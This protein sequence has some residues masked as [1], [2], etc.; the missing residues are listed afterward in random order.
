MDLAESYLYSNIKSDLYGNIKSALYGNTNGIAQSDSTHKDK[1]KVKLQ[2][3]TVLVVQSGN[4]QRAN[5]T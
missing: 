2:M 3:H 1:S 5:K 4:T